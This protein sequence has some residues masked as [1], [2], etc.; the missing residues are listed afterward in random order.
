M[1]V[2]QAMI[3]V[4]LLLLIAGCGLQKTG[5]DSFEQK[6][7]ASMDNPMITNYEMIEMKE[8]IDDSIVKNVFKKH[9]Y[10]DGYELYINKA[11]KEA[12]LIIR[13]VSEKKYSIIENEMEKAMRNALDKGEFSEYTVKIIPLWNQTNYTS[14]FIEDDKLA[15]E[16]FQ[17]LSSNK[18]IVVQPG[19]QF[20]STDGRMKVLDLTFTANGAPITDPYL[21][22]QYAN[23]FYR[24]SR[25]KGFKADDTAVYFFHNGNKDWR[26]KF[27]PA[28]EKGLKELK[29]LHVTSVTI[30]SEKDPIIINISQNSTDPN[31]IKTSEHIEKLVNEFLQYEKIKKSFPKPFTL[32]ILSSDGQIIN[33]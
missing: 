3:G 30:I 5:N 17:E 4:C 25:E 26:L 22:N 24:L 16:I 19:I 31:A 12:V 13:L 33:K 14:R 21:I 20:A 7:E 2:I 23:E 32:S 1:K 29:D 9:G 11:V 18:Q 10:P 15:K 28:L 6:A 8:K 27:I